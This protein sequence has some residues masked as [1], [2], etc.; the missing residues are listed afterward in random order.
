LH[1][2]YLSVLVKAP[3]KME[4]TEIT[5]KYAFRDCNRSKDRTYIGQNFEI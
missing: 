2:S 4:C 5:E 3:E 1:I